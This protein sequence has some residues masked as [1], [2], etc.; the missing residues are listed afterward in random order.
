MTKPL[1]VTFAP[2]SLAAAVR[3]ASGAA[4]ARAFVLRTSDAFRKVAAMSLG[5][6]R[7]LNFIMNSVLG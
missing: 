1:A 2:A 6:V 3:V 7:K 5:C 4:C